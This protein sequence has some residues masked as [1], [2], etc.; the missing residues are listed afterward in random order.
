[1]AIQRRNNG[2]RFGCG[3]E[4]ITFRI[5]ARGGDVVNASATQL[6]RSAGIDADTSRASCFRS[7]NG[8]TAMRAL[9]GVAVGLQD[10]RMNPGAELAWRPS[11]AS[12]VSGTRS[13]CAPPCRRRSSRRRSPNEY[14]GH[15]SP[16]ALTRPERRRQRQVAPPAHLAP[17]LGYLLALQ[18]QMEVSRDAG[19]GP[20][21]EYLSLDPPMWKGCGW[22][23]KAKCPVVVEE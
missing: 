18:V 17:I 20:I 9:L 1:M 11:Q 7:V 14:P 6:C 12:I 8:S 22:V 16:R 19:P 23:V 3:A 5:A 10:G 15:R 2:D 13:C 21:G 4:S